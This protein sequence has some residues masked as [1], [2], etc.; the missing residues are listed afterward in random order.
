MEAERARKIEETV[1]EILKKTNLEEA[2]EFKVRVAAS[3]LLGIDLSE[4]AEY[5]TLVRS[6]VDK[7]LVSEEQLVLEKRNNEGGD[8]FICKL[9]EKRNVMVHDFRGKT[10]VSIREFYR[11]DGKQLP[12]GKGISLSAEQWSA[13]K[14]S[15]PAIEEVIRKMDSKLRSELDGKQTEDVSNSTTDDHPCELRIETGRFDGKNYQVWAQQMEL[16][17]KQLKIEYVLTEICQSV[18][19]GPEASIQEINQAKAAEQKWFNDDYMCF[20]HILNS[21]SDNLFNLYSK[22]T[23]TAKELWEELKLFY[24]CEEYGPKR[25][26]V[27]KYI[28]FQMVEEKSVLEQVQEINNIADSIVAAGMPIEERFHVSVII[29]KL[30]PSWK[31]LY[32]KLMCEEYLP[33]WMLMNRLGVEEELRNQ[34]K[35]K[36]PDLVGY[37]NL[38]DKNVSGMRYPKPHFFHSKKRDLEMDNKEFVEKRNG[39]NGSLP[40]NTEVNMVDGAANS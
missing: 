14:K 30:P 13:F 5:K 3:E 17:L 15:V 33:F 27:K 12:S 26:Q 31:D 9:S 18:T 11:N 2:T 25:S 4:R 21:L 24:L 37:N 39:D 8:R 16:L 19:L 7:F 10:L 36:V 23:M 6:T 34:G 32:V 20:S 40:A 1:V 29:S 22:K 38:P 28:E 35:Q